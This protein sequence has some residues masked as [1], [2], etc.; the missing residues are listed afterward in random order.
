MSI[1]PTYSIFDH[2]FYFDTN[3]ARAFGQ[4]LI[5]AYLPFNILN[6]VERIPPLPKHVE[7]L[8]GDTIGGLANAIVPAFG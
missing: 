2:F 1:G 8:I 5:Y 6:P 7:N 3:L 4:P